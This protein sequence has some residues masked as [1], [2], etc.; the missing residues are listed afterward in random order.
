M[1]LMV[2][3]RNLFAQLRISRTVQVVKAKEEGS[4]KAQHVTNSKCIEMNLS[5]VHFYALTVC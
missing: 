3:N 4:A 1:F 2:N 5:K